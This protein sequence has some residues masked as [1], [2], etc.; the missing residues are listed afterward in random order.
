MSFPPQQSPSGQP[1]Q[2]LPP[3]WTQPPGAPHP[4]PEGWPG[5]QPPQQVMQP[6]PGQPMP[7]M[8]FDPAYDRRQQQK[9]RELSWQP[10][11]WKWMDLISFVAYVLILLLG[12]GSLIFLV[13]GFADFVLG[14]APDPEAARAD[15]IDGD[16][17]TIVLFTLNIVN[18]LVLVVLVLFACA[19]PLWRSLKY[20]ATWWW[21][22]VLAIP[23]LWFGTIMLSALLV[24]ILGEPTTSENQATIEKMTQETPY[25]AMAIPVVIAGPLVEEYIFRHLMI[26]KLSRVISIWVAAPLSVVAFT[27]LHFIADPNISLVSVL[28][29]FVLAIVI[30][31]TY[32]FTKFSLAYAYILHVFNNFVALSMA[33]LLPKELL[34]SDA[35][36]TFKVLGF[37]WNLTSSWVGLG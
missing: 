14:F 7:P 34:D 21:A 12:L 30:T 1:G 18:Y 19:K 37:L 35:L 22:K 9:A 17:P 36:P 4:I 32:I 6:Y 13:P 33:Y 5:K 20:F 15:M 11:P 8:G 27:G 31:G 2:P 29:Y 3:G 28:P 10:G 25:W 24:T 23:G 16:P 26:G